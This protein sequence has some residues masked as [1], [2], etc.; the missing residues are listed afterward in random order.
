M[1]QLSIF[2]YCSFPDLDDITLFQLVDYISSSL[3]LKFKFNYKLCLYQAK[4]KNLI[5]SINF[6]RYFLSSQ[7]VCSAFS[8]GSLFV[9]LDIEG[10]GFGVGFACDSIQETIDSIKSYLERSSDER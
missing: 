3:N 8:L 2:D 4:K 10:P 9:S 1:I 6:A 5:I 7:D